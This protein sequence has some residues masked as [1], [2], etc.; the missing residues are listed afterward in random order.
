MPHDKQGRLVAVG[1]VIRFIDYAGTTRAGVVSRVTPGA[2]TCNV[3]VGVAVPR[4]AIE[5][6]TATAADVELLAKGDGSA[7]A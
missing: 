7:L 6:Y 5:T 3:E 4:T 1:D 2:R